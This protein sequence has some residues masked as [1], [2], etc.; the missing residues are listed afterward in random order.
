MKLNFRDYSFIS[1]I[2][3]FPFILL[4]V[5]LKFSF[6]DKFLIS[7]YVF[8]ILIIILSMVF[9]L[10]FIISL[11]YT[12]DHIIYKQ[13]KVTFKIIHLILLFL[14][15]LIYVPFYY[16]FFIN[17]EKIIGIFVPLINIFLIVFFSFSVKNLYLSYSLKLDKDTILIKDD[18]TYISKDG[19]F[20]IE[21]SIDYSCDKTLGDYVVSCDNKLDDSFIGIYN[22]NYQ[23][24]SMG[25]LD[26]IYRFH[27]NQSKTYIKEAGFIYKEE[28]TNDIDI[29]TYNNDM[30]VLMKKIDYD[31]NNDHEYDY[32]LVI[33]KE[34]LY[35]ENMINDF[36]NLINSIQFVG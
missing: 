31:I 17:D 35:N 25:Q 22:Y 8:W 18:F 20:S 26:E 19:L 12:L 33:I 7:G 27:L 15:N 34:V 5:S 9:I 36:N 11:F 6:P 29:L 30:C 10:S 4:L 16:A 28:I 32:R 3:L 23:N 13:K 2:A 14:F 1:F 21:T 24:Y